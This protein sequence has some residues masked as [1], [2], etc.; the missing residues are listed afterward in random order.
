MQPE[1]DKQQKYLM[2]LTPVLFIFILYRFP[3]GLMLY[4]VTTN[5]WTIMQ[6]IIIRRTAPRR[7]LQPAGPKPPGRFMRALNAAQV[8]AVDTQ[9]Q[10]EERLQERHVEGR[11]GQERHREERRQGHGFGAALRQTRHRQGNRGPKE[12]GQGGRRPTGAKRPGKHP[13]ARAGRSRAQAP[14]STEWSERWTKVKP[15][16]P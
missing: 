1:T 16:T 3:A 9:E 15:T 13:R 4:W 12:H 14:Q 7:Q 6:Q 8:K 2:R 11:H 10:A 5:L